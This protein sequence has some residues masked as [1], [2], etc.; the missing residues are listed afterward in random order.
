MSEYV[1]RAIEEATSDNLNFAGA[2]EVLYLGGGLTILGHPCFKPYKSIG[3]AKQ[4][5]KAWERHFE[6]PVW[7]NGWKYTIDSI[8][9][10]EKHMEQ[11]AKERIDREM[12]KV[13]FVLDKL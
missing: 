3:G 5:L 8:V 7:K 12:K 6:H 9:P 4:G 11:E 1:I 10:Y 2:K 13:A